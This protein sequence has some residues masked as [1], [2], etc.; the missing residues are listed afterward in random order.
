MYLQAKDYA[1]LKILFLFDI[2]NGGGGFYTAALIAHWFGSSSSTYRYLKRL[3]KGKYLVES[4]K[5]TKRGTVK[6]WHLTKLGRN[7]VIYNWPMF[8]GFI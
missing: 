5:E 7:K 3:T 6:C 4:T 1:M 8:K 2:L